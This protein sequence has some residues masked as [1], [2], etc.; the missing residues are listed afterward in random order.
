MIKKILINTILGCVAVIVLCVAVT[1][2][3]ATM[4]TAFMLSTIL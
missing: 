1:T 4:Y 3:G 2:V